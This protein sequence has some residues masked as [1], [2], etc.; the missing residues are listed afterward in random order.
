Y[1]VCQSRLLGRGS[2]FVFSSEQFRQL[3]GVTSDW[4]TKRLLDLGAG[5]GGVTQ[6]M[7]PHFEEIYTTEVSATM[8]WQLQKKQ[9]KVLEIDEWQKAGFKYDVISCLNLLDRCEQPITLL[10]DIRRALEPTRGRVILATVLPF[11]ASV[12]EGM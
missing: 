8:R 11:H 6:I 4:R 3:L 10:N 5:D 1:I 12:E 7:S 2:M 9:Y